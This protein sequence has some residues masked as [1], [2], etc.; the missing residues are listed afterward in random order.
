MAHPQHGRTHAYTLEEIASLEARGWA[1]DPKPVLSTFAQAAGRG[2]PVP[3]A[4]Q[5]YADPPQK[6][7]PGRKPKAK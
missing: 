4:V 2:Y 6:K 7:K 5:F 1:L 3:D